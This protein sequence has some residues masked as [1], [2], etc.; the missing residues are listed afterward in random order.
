M[1][2]RDYLTIARRRWP[3]I[4]LCGLVAGGVTWFITP[5]ETSQASTAPSYTATATL[6]VGARSPEEQ[7]PLDRIALYV[8][9]GEIP[10]RAA[11]VLGFE[12]DPAVL[13]SQVVVTPDPGAEALTIAASD[14][15]GDKAAATAN[16]FA[17]QTVAYFKKARPGT[18]RASVSVL[19]VATPIPDDI[20]GGFVVPPSR[21]LR[22]GIATLVGL[23]L[24][25]ALALVLERL[26]SRLRSGDQVHRALRLP[27]IAEVPRLTHAQKRKAKITV[28]ADPLA[29]YS[30]AYRVARAALM[31]TVSRQVSGDYLARRAAGPERRAAPTGARL[32][33][34][35][36]ANASDGKTTSVANLAASFAETGQRVLVLDGDLR[37]PDTHSLFD[38]PQGAGISDYISDPG[39]VSLDALVRPTSVPGVR[40][41]TAGTRLAHPESLSSRMGHLL[42][43]VRG[44]AD[45]VLIDSPPLLAAGDVFDVLPI[46]DTVLLVVRSGKLTDVAARRVAE[47]LGRFE[48]PISGVVLVGAKGRRAD[49]YGYGYGSSK[50]QKRG[51]ASAAAADV[52]YPQQAERVASP[53][54][55]ADDDPAGWPVAVSPDTSSDAQFPSRRA[56]RTSPSA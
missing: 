5:A 7:V 55:T 2:L 37:S 13:A 28:A 15:D 56:R 32:I 18:G 22:T 51:R 53:P 47:L 52:S 36:S 23:L 12:D 29:P 25:F 39:D 26:D 30:D 38:V 24:G 34:V 33:L 8:K 3:I 54:L 16:A 17:D 6:L 19:Q 43:E 44:M 20:G 45:V 48:V 4:L 41:I 46:V 10:T 1:T 27:I 49:G 42:T 35:T 11:R 50:K 9:T 31:H 21:A 14:A 40:I